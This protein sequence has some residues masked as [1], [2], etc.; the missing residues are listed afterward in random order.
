MDQACTEL[1]PFVSAGCGGCTPATWRTTERNKE[2]KA[3]LEDQGSMFVA[4]TAAEV[5]GE[6]EGEGEAAGQAWPAEAP[7]GLRCWELAA[8]PVALPQ[9]APPPTL[10]NS[11][12]SSA[13]YVT[14]FLISAEHKELIASGIYSSVPGA[15]LLCPTWRELTWCPCWYSRGTLQLFW[16][17]WVCSTCLGL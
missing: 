14:S 9:L 6:E 4:A 11:W 16:Y 8:T 12:C 3:E 1:L 17:I 10:T 5:R 15:E 2:T 7:E 13:H